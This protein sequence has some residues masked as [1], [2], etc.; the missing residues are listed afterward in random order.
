MRERRIKPSVFL[1]HSKK[2]VEFI[3]KLADDLRNCQ[4]DPWIDELEIRHGKPWLDEI[5]ES[6]IPSCHI[7]IAYITE[8]SIESRMVR[9]EIDASILQKLA[10]N[11]ISFMPYVSASDLHPRLRIDIQ[12]LQ[13]P[14]FNLEN[15]QVMLPR[16][17]AQI[18]GS[19]L[20]WAVAQAVQS[21]KIQRLELELKLHKIEQENNGSIFSSSEHNEFSHIW[22]KLNRNQSIRIVKT[23]QRNKLMN[24][25]FLFDVH[26]PT[27]YFSIIYKMKT[28]IDYYEINKEI[29]RA[30]ERLESNLTTLPGEFLQVISSIKFDNEFLSYGFLTR[31]VIPST[32]GFSGNQASQLK[33]VFTDKFDRFNFWLS[34]NVQQQDLVVLLRKV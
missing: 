30:A 23:D 12:S 18:W 22:S 20:D 15:Y 32:L 2:D 8:N 25:E 24:S 9:Q 19:Y 10:N 29:E 16:V 5:F 33:L 17:V 27:L 7:V 26:L 34:Q 3:K 28:E 21:E 1:S 11:N 31:Q 13:A 6:G 14:V 4:I